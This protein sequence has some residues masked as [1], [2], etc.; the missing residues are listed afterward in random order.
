MNIVFHAANDLP[1]DRCTPFDLLALAVDEASAKR[2]PQSLRFMRLAMERSIEPEYAA[3]GET[4]LRMYGATQ[5]WFQYCLQV[6][7]EEQATKSRVYFIFSK[8]QNAIKI[9][10]TIDPDQRLAT[11]QGSNPDSLDLLRVI[12][13]GLELEQKLHRRFKHLKRGGEWFDA[14]PELLKFINSLRDFK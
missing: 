8:K 12:P 10:Y 13:G 3:Q 9:G 14:A 4:F 1:V 7:E 5:A 6:N 11:I 2:F